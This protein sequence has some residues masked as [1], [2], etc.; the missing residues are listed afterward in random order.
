MKVKEI[1]THVIINIVLFT[2]FTS[3]ANV[4]IIS[5]KDNEGNIF[6][7]SFF[8]NKSII[9]TYYVTRENKRIKVCDNPDKNA[10]IFK[11]KQSLR[12]FVA[13]NYI[14]PNDSDVEG[15]FIVAML[16]NEDGKIVE[17]RVL[18]NIQSFPEYTPSMLTLLDKITTA[19][20][21]IKNGK[22]VKSIA[23]LSIPIR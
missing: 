11:D 17:Y 16:V 10:I 21:A 22:P 7:L 23:I 6:K 9:K 12:D 4:T 15:V 8:K 19:E 1:L 14:W 13:D 5:P 2:C 3:C 20:P 18:K